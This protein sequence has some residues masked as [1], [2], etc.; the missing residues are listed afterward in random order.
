MPTPFAPTTLTELT[1]RLE[2]RRHAAIRLASTLHDDALRAL[3]DLDRSDFFDS[4]S[5][6]GGTNDND[7]ARS[8]QLARIASST[9]RA[10]DQALARLAAGTYGT[11]EGCHQRIP[12]ARLRAMP[13]TGLCVGCKVDE[14]RVM[15]L[16]G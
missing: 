8:L 2:Q 6:D 12:L 11:C 10:A 4:E 14:S 3:E 1:I 9:A 7:R 5:P 15:A 16:A 13:E